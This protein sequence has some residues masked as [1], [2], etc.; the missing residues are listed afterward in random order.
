MSTQQTPVIIRKASPDDV[1]AVKAIADANR[2][3]I[4]FVLR[5]VLQEHTRRGWLYVAGTPD[6]VVGF[7][8]F[9]HR[10]DGWTVVYE[11]CVEASARKQGIGFQLLSQLYADGMCQGQRGIRLKCPEGSPANEFYATIGFQCIGVAPGK[12]RNLV[13]W[14]WKR[15]KRYALCTLLCL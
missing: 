4:G 8:N 7:V 5:P 1:Q 11:I 6:R 2:E 15:W 10:R 9:R 12:Q 3:S 13:L 14:Q